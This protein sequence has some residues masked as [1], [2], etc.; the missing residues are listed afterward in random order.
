MNEALYNISLEMRENRIDDLINLYGYYCESEDETNKARAKDSIFTAI[1]NFFR[2]LIEMIGNIFSRKSNITF[3]DYVKDPNVKIK[4]DKDIV[5]LQEQVHREVIEGNKL[6]N[7]ISN[8]TPISDETLAKWA[9]NVDN[10]C[11]HKITPK[12]VEKQTASVTRNLLL[13]VTDKVSAELRKTNKTF[14]QLKK[15]TNMSKSEFKKYK[16]SEKHKVATKTIAISTPLIIVQNGL[17][18]LGK[19]SLSIA[20]SFVIEKMSKK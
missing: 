12:D 10:L 5:N 1:A 13:P 17:K 18:K 15:T 8:H 14:K 9:K 3:D 2:D 20:N 4:M 16:A 19:K 6:L 7:F 11:S